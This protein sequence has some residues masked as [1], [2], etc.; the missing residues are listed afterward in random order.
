MSIIKKLIGTKPSQVP[1][2]RDLGTMAY[3]D[4]S[5][6]NGPA[7]F[8]WM[9]NNQSINSATQTKAEYNGEKFDTHNCYDTATYRF[10][11]T[12]AG[13][14]FVNASASFSATG[15]TYV[16]STNI[17]KNGTRW[18]SGDVK[19]TGSLADNVRA[20]SLVPMNGST[21]YLEIFLYQASGAALT[22][23]GGDFNFTEFSAFFVRGL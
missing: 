8:A 22:I 7:F 2:N 23:N 3:Q 19:I 16:V 13:Y 17:Y 5:L 11:P 20:S 21:D 12:M 9:N 10:T 6:V 18:M 15:S 4:V 14:Y 1:R